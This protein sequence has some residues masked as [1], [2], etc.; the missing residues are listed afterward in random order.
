M[1]YALAI[2]TQRPSLVPYVARHRMALQKE[3]FDHLF[4]SQIRMGDA[5]S[6]GGEPESSDLK[7]AYVFTNRGVRIS[8]GSHSFFKPSKLA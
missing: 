1:S 5:S 4:P 2:V 6:C 8:L 7:L 3:S